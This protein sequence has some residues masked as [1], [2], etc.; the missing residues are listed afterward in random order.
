VSVLLESNN[1]TVRRAGSP[2]LY[3]PALKLEHGGNMLL[4]GASG[5]GKTTWLSVL[6]GLL[7]PT[8][9]R[10]LFEGK[11]IHAL[12]ARACDKLRGCHYGF[13]FQTL[14]LLPSLTLRQNIALAADMAGE[15]PDDKR[16]ARLLGTLGLADKAH[17]KPD[18]LSQGEQQRAAIARAVLNRPSLIV[19][20]EP[21]SALDDVN[22]HV[23]V[24]LLEEQ[25]K[26]TGAALLI[27]THDN[28]I[29][30]RFQNIVTL[31]ARM[32][33]PA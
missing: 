23:V 13:V 11:D 10:V 16:I 29:K 3:F 25:A 7:K 22:A 8:E 32:K 26:D 9:G 14:H 30:S 28:R 4:L 12:P 6:A 24:D 31:D 33:D 1:I 15:K 5:C 18:A 17:R 21:T 19:A 27:A 20:D 2:P